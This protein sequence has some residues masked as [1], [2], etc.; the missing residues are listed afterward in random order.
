MSPWSSVVTSM[1][2]RSEIWKIVLKSFKIIDEGFYRLDSPEISAHT[3]E[4]PHDC[5][6]RKLATQR[7]DVVENK[8]VSAKWSNYLYPVLVVGVYSSQRSACLYAPSFCTSFAVSGSL[9]TR[10]VAASAD[11][12][13]LGELVD[14]YADRTLSG[15]TQTINRPKAPTSRAI[16]CAGR[17]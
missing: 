6:V 11:S 13:D 2:T 8:T 3:P 5:R 12:V 15:Y 7:H 17:S 9:L 16:D 10:A 4:H 14:G 1:D